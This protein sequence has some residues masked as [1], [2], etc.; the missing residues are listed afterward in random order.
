[1]G[2]T[3]T[4]T[5]IADPIANII[6]AAADWNIK[7]MMVS[8]KGRLMGNSIV[9]L[10]TALSKI[11]IKLEKQH[12]NLARFIFLLIDLGAAQKK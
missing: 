9:H 11:A 8:A 4:T 7:T 10:A 5:A 1:M 2:I 6:A 12:A 3:V